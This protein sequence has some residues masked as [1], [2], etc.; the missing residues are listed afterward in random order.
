MSASKAKASGTANGPTG[1][2][3]S[4]SLDQVRDILVG[5]QMRTIEARLS[6]LEESLRR[7]LERLEQAFDARITELDK[8][9]RQSATQ[10]GSTLRGELQGEARRWE[11]ALGKLGGELRAEL[12]LVAGEL[13]ARKPDS[14]ALAE[15]LREVV[16]RLEGGASATTSARR[17]DTKSR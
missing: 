9:N 10:A 3:A 17:S 4:E 11:A 7:E 15:A 8:Q 16:R 6:Q 13:G 2:L 14:A 12:A 1:T 5:A